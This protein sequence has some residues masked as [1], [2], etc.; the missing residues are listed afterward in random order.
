MMA[1]AA[2][3]RKKARTPLVVNKIFHVKF[4]WFSDLR[5]KEEKALYKGKFSTFAVKVVVVR[6][7]EK[8]AIVKAA[9]RLFCEEVPFSMLYRKMNDHVYINLASCRKKQPLG[10]SLVG[11]C[12]DL[13]T[14]FSI[15]TK[16]SRKPPRRIRR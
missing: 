6:L 9:S 16:G 3:A 15:K 11:N 14:L 7:Y 1:S 5:S 13:A 8:S 4:N 12:I 10:R 2:A